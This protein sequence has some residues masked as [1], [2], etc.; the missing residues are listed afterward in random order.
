MFAIPVC[1][2]C[3]AMMQEY[4]P[5][6]SLREVLRW[7]TPHNVVTTE[8]EVHPMDQP[9]SMDDVAS[10]Q[11][12][13]RLVVIDTDRGANSSRAFQASG[14]R[15]STNL[16]RSSSNSTLFRLTLD[17]TAIAQRKFILLQASNCRGDLSPSVD[18]ALP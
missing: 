14:P 1:R 6:V 17:Q 3:F 18:A 11:S 8:E 4:V 2:P 16:T 10:P 15:S 9:R 7:N 13:P 12:P 5:S